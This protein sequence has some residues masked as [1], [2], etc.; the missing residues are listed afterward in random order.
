M[1]ELMMANEM[2]LKM[3]KLVK[4]KAKS[5]VCFGVIHKYFIAV[6]DQFSSSQYNKQLGPSRI[7]MQNLTV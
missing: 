1:K 2:E 7:I 3:N 6:F 4:C 5:L